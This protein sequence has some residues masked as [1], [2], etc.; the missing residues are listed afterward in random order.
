MKIVPVLC[1]ALLV[2]GIASGRPLVLE[3]TN[4]F[5]DTAEFIG[6]SGN[7]AFLTNTIWEDQSDPDLPQVVTQVVKL[8][9]RGANGQ[10]MY[11]R[12]I[13]SERNTWSQN[14]GYNLDVQ[15]SVAAVALPSGLHIFERTS[16]GWL[17]SSLDIPRPQGY[18]VSVDSGR[19]LAIETGEPGVCALEA[20]VLERGTNGHWN[21]S[22]HLPAPAGACVSFFAL[23]ANAAALL[24]HPASQTQGVNS[25]ALRVFERS[26]SAWIQ[27]AQFAST[28]S[29]TYGPQLYGP[30]LD[31]HSGL[32]LVSSTDKGMHVYRRGSSGWTEG[33]PLKFPDSYDYGGEEARSIQ[34]TDAYVLAAGYNNNRQTDAAYLFRN[35]PAN[36]FPHLAVLTVASSNGLNDGVI[37][38]NRVLANGFGFPRIYELP[39]SFT[40]RPVVQDDFEAGP[41]PWQI[42][43]GSQ[44]SVV[45]KGPSHVWRQSSL[46]G[47]AGAMLNVDRTNQSVSADITATAVNGNDRWVGLVTRYTDESNY[48]YLTVRGLIDDIERIVLK[49]MQNGVWTDLATYPVA[50]GVQLNQRIR[51][52]LESTGNY[53]AVFLDNQ[54]LM[55][56]YDGAHPH[57]KAGLRMFK[58]AAEFD[59]VVLT[60]GPLMRQSTL[61]PATAGGTWMSAPEGWPHGRA[62]QTS[63]EGNARAMFGTPVEDSIAT[64]ML[65]I[66][67]FN[68][69]GTPWAGLMSRYVNSSNYYYVTL[70]KSNELSLRKL[71][72]GV[73]TVLGTVPLTVTPGTAYRVRFETVGD[74]LRVFVNDQL[75]LERAGAQIVAGRTGVVMYRAR[76]TLSTYALFSP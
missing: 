2:C 65:R 61:G 12:D 16:G 70:R 67:A 47:N 17:E 42:L 24:S 52:T 14:I 37:E 66:D 33:E 49:R 48:Y 6:L 23:D 73:I 45:Q 51:L 7:Q 39:A 74:R 15:G 40:P 36:A 32:A 38:G 56:A 34:I 21:I 76:A 72:N 44:F 22:A 46:A 50:T 60:P 4:T 1:G 28:E 29:N 55:R 35:E 75:K 9:Q 57:G 10:W 41:G 63:L 58:A 13:I 18:A 5:P 64:A 25:T 31:I 59:N 27:A 71:T 20:V 26:G 11:V 19:V 54:L 69:A 53:H 3:P 30:S 43:P 62:V 68:A 8:Y